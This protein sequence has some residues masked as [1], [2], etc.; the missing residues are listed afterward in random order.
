MQ[1]GQPGRKLNESVRIVVGQ[2]LQRCIHGGD[3]GAV[4]GWIGVIS[5]LS[6]IE[7]LGELLW[8][9]YGHGFSEIEL[10]LVSEIVC[11]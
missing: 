11:R 1:I 10:F 6:C 3:R 4:D 9:G 5:F 2:R 7:H 8:C